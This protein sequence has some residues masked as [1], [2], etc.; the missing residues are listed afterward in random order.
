MTTPSKTPFWRLVPVTVAVLVMVGCALSKVNSRYNRFS[1]ELIVTLRGIDLAPANV[2]SATSL[3]LQTEFVAPGILARR[4][5][6]VTISITS[7]APK[8]PYREDHG[9][10]L[11]ADGLAVALEPAGY[12]ATTHQGSLVE[13]MWVKVTT[14]VFLQVIQAKTL[15]GRIGPTAFALTPDQLADLREFATSLP[16]EKGYKIPGPFPVQIPGVP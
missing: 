8:S 3:R 2:W 5:E 14:H 9:L 1:D 15:T 7:S 4:P 6:F 16:P 11:V 10:T 13:Y 12:D